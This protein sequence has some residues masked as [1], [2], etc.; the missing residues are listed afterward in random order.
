MGNDRRAGPRSLAK[1]VA[2]TRAL[3]NVQSHG[4][5]CDHLIEVLDTLDD[6]HIPIEPAT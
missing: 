3:S 2:K 1:S 6:T 5:Q 4:T